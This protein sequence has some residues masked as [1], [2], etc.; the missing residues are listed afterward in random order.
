MTKSNLKNL[1][2]ITV[3]TLFLWACTSAPK[4]EAKT[5]AAPAEKAKTYTQ[6]NIGGDNYMKVPSDWTLKENFMPKGYVS[7]TI[8][9]DDVHMVV[10][11]YKA[12]RSSFSIDKSKKDLASVTILYRTGSKLK[13]KTYK[14]ITDNYKVGGYTHHTCSSNTKCYQVF[15]LSN[16]RSVI[17]ADFFAGGMK[18]TITAG[19]DNLDGVHAEDVV[20]AIKSVQDKA[21]MKLTQK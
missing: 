11:G 14:Q 17:A 8:K 9:N 2:I 15:P 13:R 5:P 19:V 20:Q 12:K 3:G 21:G 10:S 6:A 7:Y 1:G 4:K 18:Y 16:W